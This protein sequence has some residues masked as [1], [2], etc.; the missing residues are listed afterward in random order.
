MDDD[1]E[2][3]P[4]SA[5][6]STTTVAERIEALTARARREREGFAPAPED[7]PAEERAM[8]Y[9]RNGFGPTVWCYVDARTGSKEILTDAQMGKLDRGT[10]DWL[11]VYARCHGTEIDL[12]LSVRAAAEVLIETHNVRDTAQLLTDVPPR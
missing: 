12:D 6:T 4:T 10:N 2:S 8:E 5:D 9:L 11:A 7:V 3:S 1:D